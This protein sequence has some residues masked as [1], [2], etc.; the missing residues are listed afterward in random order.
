MRNILLAAAAATFAL[1]AASPALAQSRVGPAEAPA[2]TPTAADEYVR[3]A[4]LSDRYEIESS[5]LA[6][7][8]A[9]SDELKRFAQH[10][11]DE[12]TATSAALMA[13]LPRAGVT[14]PD[15]SAPD[16]LRQGLLD[17]LQQAQNGGEF[18]RR[19]RGQQLQAHREALALHQNYAANGDNAVLR[20]LAAQTASRVAHHLEML[21]GMR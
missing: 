2:P 4:A 5:R 8:R 6:I 7:G 18:D 13:A 16:R 14:A 17:A 12:H 15:I 21:N 10:M 3:Q 1:T 11:I 20:E 19:Y 9:Q